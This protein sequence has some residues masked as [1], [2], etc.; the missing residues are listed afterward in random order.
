MSHVVSI[1]VDVRQREA[2]PSCSMAWFAHVQAVKPLSISLP[3]MN[4]TSFHD[5][6]GIPIVSS[7]PSRPV[8]TASSTISMFWTCSSLSPRRRRRSW[9]VWLTVEHEGEN[10]RHNILY[11]SDRDYSRQGWSSLVVT[12]PSTRHNLLAC[13]LCAGVGVYCVLLSQIFDP[14]IW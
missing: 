8:L 5:E 11:F 3:N 4:E 6:G 10:T 1:L 2:W 12:K 7:R 14:I 13:I 9:I